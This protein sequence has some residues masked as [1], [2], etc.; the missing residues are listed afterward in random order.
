MTHYV[1]YV[2]NKPVHE[3]DEWWIAHELHTKVNAVDE[4]RGL[5]SYTEI[6]GEP[7]WGITPEEQKEPRT[8]RRLRTI[9]NNY[10]RT[11]IIDEQERERI[12]Q[13]KWI[14]IVNDVEKR[15]TEIRKK[16]A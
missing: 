11:C 4:W 13:K 3:C 10:L 2:D 9:R 7:L 6:D 8:Q 1:I 12:A 14:T 16:G 5:A 15:F